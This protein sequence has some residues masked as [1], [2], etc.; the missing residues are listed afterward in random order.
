SLGVQN[1][2]QTA[3][4]QSVEV[5]AAYNSGLFPC[6]TPGTPTAALRMGWDNYTSVA[7]SPNSGGFV[8]PP[9]RIVVAYVVETSGPTRELHRLRCVDA[10]TPISDVVVAHGLTAVAPVVTCSSTCTAA[11]PPRRI[12]LTLSL[13][14]PGGTGTYPVDL[15]GERRQT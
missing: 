8:T 6:G 13:V 15:T 14:D 7:T 10:T 11:S 5:G 9:K 1:A 12:T 3:L 4:Q 2:D